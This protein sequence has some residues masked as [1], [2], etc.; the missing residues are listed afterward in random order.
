MVYCENC[1]MIFGGKSCPNC[2][3]KDGRAPMPTDLVFLIEKGSLWSGMIA[4]VLTQK[5]IPYFVKQDIPIAIAIKLGSAFVHDRFYVPYSD[6]HKAKELMIG[7]FCRNDLSNDVEW[8][9]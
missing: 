8:F 9:G 6:Y 5:Q 1:N 7:L 2:G 4:D 3:A